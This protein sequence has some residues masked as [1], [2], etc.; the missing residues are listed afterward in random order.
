MTEINQSANALKEMNGFSKSFNVVD[1]D[2][3]S[4]SILCRISWEFSDTMGPSVTEEIEKMM[5][6]LSDRI[7]DLL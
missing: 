4:V 5:W 1:Q 7:S 2:G 3:K 6:E